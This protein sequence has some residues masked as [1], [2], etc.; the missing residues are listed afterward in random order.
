MRPELF[1]IQRTGPGSLSTMAGPRGGAWLDREISGLAAA[2]VSVLVS[3][4]TDD[5]MAELELSA[6]AEAARA[7]GLEFYRL[8][9]EDRQVPDLEAGLALARTLSA[10]LQRGAGVAVHCRFGIGR[11]STVAAM[12]LVLEGMDPEQALAR[13][14]AA[15]GVPVPDTGPQREAVLSLWPGQPGAPE[16]SSRADDALAAPLVQDG[17]DPADT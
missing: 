9:T 8:P 12:V 11:S 1:T 4:L 3:L 17:P 6:E 7:S 16:R 14:S 5:E 10:H 2:G 15:R 13:I